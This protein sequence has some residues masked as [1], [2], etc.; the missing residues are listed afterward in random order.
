MSQTD[1]G[2]YNQHIPLVS[3]DILII[4]TN[5][6]PNQRHDA[7][8]S[9]YLLNEIEEIVGLGAGEIHGEGQKESPPQEHQRQVG[10]LHGLLSLSLEIPEDKKKRRGFLG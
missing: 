7:N 1:P 8:I 10:V 6:C 4:P 2:H 5:Q 9:A 3:S